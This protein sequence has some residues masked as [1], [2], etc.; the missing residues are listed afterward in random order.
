MKIIK[1]SI[2]SAYKQYNANSRNNFSEDCVK[3]AITLA[4]GMDYDDVSKQL[5]KIKRDINADAYNV[6]SVFNRFLKDRGLSFKS[7]PERI[8]VEE[9]CEDH[10]DGT[11]L[12]LTGSKRTA[13]RG[14]SNHM[15][16]VID[17]DVYDSWD[18]TKEIVISQCLVSRDTSQFEDL[19]VYQI[20]QDVFEIVS[21]YLFKLS[22]KSTLENL[23]IS[24]QSRNFK[25]DGDDGYVLRYY[26]GGRT[27]EDMPR[28]FKY[29]P[30]IRYSHMISV[31]VNPRLSY[32][33]NVKLL[34]KKVKQKMY[35]WIYN[36]DKEVKDARR[37]RNLDVS[38]DFKG[39]VDDLRIV[40]DWA[41]P[42]VTNIYP[43]SYPYKYE[44]YMKALPGD[45]R[46]DEYTEVS[47]YADSLSEL[48]W[49]FKAYKEK[50][51][52]YQYDY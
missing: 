51:S 19:D 35:D 50:F 24:E 41:V 34:A 8:S 49:E 13:V 28:S 46:E 33:D 27:P 21:D 9:F 48:K 47:F 26:I 5:N 3:R 44:V 15:L 11:Y 12:L 52:R 42:Y 1:D 20:G 40:P 30:N 2:T 32:D 6:P 7:V 4:L 38:P 45:P 37:V 36:M 31:K 14:I 18:S 16:C 39:D 23:D 10:P 22:K 29:R 25:E 43:D 17:G